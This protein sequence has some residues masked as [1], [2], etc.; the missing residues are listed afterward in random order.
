MHT[1]RL[2][3]YLFFFTILQTLITYCTIILCE[4]LLKSTGCLS[5]SEYYRS[6]SLELQIEEHCQLHKND[7]EV[8]CSVNR[9]GTIE[10]NIGWIDVYI[11]HPKR[12]R[13]PL[14]N[15][16]PGEEFEYFCSFRIFLD[17]I[18]NQSKGE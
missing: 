17:D 3:Y 9:L 16:K 7:A 8:Y 4:V 5:I 15:F 18:Y 6:T 2:V 13:G 1:W 11:S 14:A 12:D 10:E